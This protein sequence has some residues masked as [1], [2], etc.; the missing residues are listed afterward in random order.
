MNMI[1]RLLVVVGLLVGPLFGHGEERTPVVYKVNIKE[2]IG[3]A[4]WRLARRSFEQALEG[5]ARYIVIHLNTYGG[6][7]IHADSLRSLILRCPVPVWVFIDNNAASAGALISIAC[8]RIYMSEGASLG[9]ATV[10]DGVGEVQPD[11]VQSYMRSMM[12][13]TAQAKGLDTVT[14]GG[15]QRVAW[16]RDPVIAEAMVDEE[17]EIKGLSERGKVLTFTAREAMK[18]GFCDGIAASVEEVIRREGVTRYELREYRVT[19]LD[20][21]IGFL[22]HPIVQ[23][24]LILII[25]AGI[26]FE[27]QTPGVGFPLVAAL[28]ACALYFAPLYIE[29]LASYIEIILFVAGVMLLLLEVFVVPGFGVTGIAGVSCIV[30]SLALAGVGSFSFDGAGGFIH[31]LLYSLFFVSSCAV[32]SLLFSLWLGRRLFRSRGLG[33]A[34]HAT[35]AVEDGFVGVDLAT[36]QE[37]GKTGVAFTDLRPAGKVM[38]AGEVYDAVSN[39]GDYIAKG[40]RVKV[41]KFQSG[42]VYVARAE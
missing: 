24:L 7:V 41:I 36:R 33:L 21:V 10:V 5:G 29:G 2:E 16:R 25:V 3:A 27:L 23:G 4:S 15:E 31:D 37:V 40:A 42:Q 1:K 13:S 22:V 32:I 9:A 17:V 39:V 30:G 26:Y 12:R 34:L 8:D 38:V 18:H 11:K 19:A 28:S 20:R 35:E 14:V 6:T